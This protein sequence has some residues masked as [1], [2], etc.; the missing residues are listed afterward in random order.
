M[1]KSESWKIR[2]LVSVLLS[3]RLASPSVVYPIAS[4]VVSC[5][6]PGVCRRWGDATLSSCCTAVWGRALVKGWKQYNRITRRLLGLDLEIGWVW[7]VPTHGE[8]DQLS[9]FSSSTITI[10]SRGEGGWHGC[11][12]YLCSS[13]SL[14]TGKVGISI[15]WLA[16]LEVMVSLLCFCEAARKIVRRQS[17]DSFAR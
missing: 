1:M 16:E 4:L 11:G 13:R 15:L 3:C 7:L 8:E 10:A 12:I 17:W 14:P 2:R 6:G 9:R 5:A